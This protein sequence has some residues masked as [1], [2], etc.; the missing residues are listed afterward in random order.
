MNKLD[1]KFEQKIVKDDDSSSLI[2]LIKSCYEEYADRGI[3]FD[4]QE[5]PD[6]LKPASYFKLHNGH[7]FGVSTTIDPERLIAVCGFIQSNPDY[8]KVHSMELKKLYVCSDY[9]G[10]G[11]AQ[12]L[13]KEVIQEAHIRKVSELLLWTDTRFTKAHQLYNKLGF[14]KQKTT[15]K[16]SDKSNTEE[17]CYR[18]TI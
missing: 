2:D 18:L 17:F 11:L 14:I 5:E 4:I 9:R 3:V 13:V 15:R 8:L 16:L 7:L 1:Q 12:H 10:C 6:L